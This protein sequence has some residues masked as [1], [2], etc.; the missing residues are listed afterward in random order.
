M[1]GVGSVTVVTTN[2][3]LDTDLVGVVTVTVLLPDMR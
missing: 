1:E 2:N 3:P